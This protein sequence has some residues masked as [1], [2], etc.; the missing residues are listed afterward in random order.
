M[1]SL[2]SYEPARFR[3]ADSRNFCFAYTANQKME[4]KPLD[5]FLCIAE[6]GSLKDINDYPL[7]LRSYGHTVSGSLVTNCNLFRR[8]SGLPSAC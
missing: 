3:P 2:A 1:G 5:W 4:L 7:N 6:T 8:T